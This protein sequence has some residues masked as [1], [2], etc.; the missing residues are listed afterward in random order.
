MYG[1]GEESTFRWLAE[2]DHRARPVYCSRFFAEFEALFRPKTALM[3]LKR[4]NKRSMSEYAELHWDGNQLKLPLING[5]AS[6]R[7]I[8]ISK[9]RDE[10]GLIT[11]DS[12][13]GNTGS[14]TSAITF[15]DGEKGILRYRG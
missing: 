6:E 7:A 2:A 14:C 5:T 9:L 11:L 10:T 13:Y 8:D 3:F 4:E 1:I 15:I 12:G